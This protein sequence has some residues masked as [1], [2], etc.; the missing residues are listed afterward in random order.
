MKDKPKE[1]PPEVLAFAR[2][3]REAFGEGVRLYQGKPWMG[4]SNKR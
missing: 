2:S 4:G 3:I 1:P